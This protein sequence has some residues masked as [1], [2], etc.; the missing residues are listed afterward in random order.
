MGYIQIALIGLLA[1]SI[2]YMVEPFIYAIDIVEPWRTGALTLFQNG[3]DE[4]WEILIGAV[5]L[6]QGGISEGWAILIGTVCGLSA[7]AW[8]IRQGFQAL[9][10][11]QQ[12][13]AQLARDSMREQTRLEREVREHQAALDAKQETLQR[14][15]AAKTLAVVL[16]EEISSIRESLINKLRIL[17]VQKDAVK[18][19]KRENQKIS[20][21]IE[22]TKTPVFDA[23]IREIGLLGPSIAGD[24][25]RIFRSVNKAFPEE[26]TFGLDEQHLAAALEVYILGIEGWLPAARHVE[27]R[28]LALVAGENDPGPLR[29]EQQRRMNDALESH[30][31]VKEPIMTP[32]MALPDETWVQDAGIADSPPHDRVPVAA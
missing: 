3:I 27:K 11:S 17:R 1:L 29:E 19:R 28:L 16:S 14:R 12:H 31:P 6:V 23:N 30:T 26:Q 21:H 10:A 9:T 7:I 8:Q 25:V 18:A 32:N 22:P 2:I 5:V 4:G 20:L 13:C 24:V 15:E